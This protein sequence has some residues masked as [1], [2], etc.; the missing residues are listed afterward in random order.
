MSGFSWIK[1]HR[2][3]DRSAKVLRLA[4]L[5]KVTDTH[6]LGIVVRLHLVV[7]ES[8]PDGCITDGIEDL[9][10]MLGIELDTCKALVQAGVLVEE[11]GCL[12][13]SGWADE[14]AIE[15]IQR[16]R[17]RDRNRQRVA[18]ESP[19]IRE[20]SASEPSADRQR[21]ASE[22]P[23]VRLRVA[24]L[25]KT[26][27][28]Q[29]RQEK[30][31]QDE[32]SPMPQAQSAGEVGLHHKEL[33]HVILQRWPADRRCNPRQVI[34]AIR[35]D[36]LQPDMATCTRIAQ[37]AS[38]W[39]QAYEQQGRSQYLPRVDN[40]ISSGAWREEP[41]KHDKE[42]TAGLSEDDWAGLLDA[43]AKIDATLKNERIN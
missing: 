37:A 4:R 36:Q 12:I 34:W 22:S 27:E 11:D 3:L 33:A 13:V 39:V 20:R 2:R 19:A 25:E 14:Q 1:V 7:A 24:D 28:D 30:T 9:T 21:G 32:T 41:P 43:A 16:K 26:R 42:D 10:D 17:E 31:R 38:N 15:A 35:A 6:A 29:T 23:A 5:A 8:Y 40:W 18:S